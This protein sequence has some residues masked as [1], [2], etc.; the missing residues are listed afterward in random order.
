MK[1]IVLSC[2]L[3]FGLVITSYAQ[4]TP[5]VEKPGMKIKQTPGKLIKTQPVETKTTPPSTTPATTQNQTT[6]V[7]TLSSVRVNIRTGN[8]NKEFPSGVYIELW[9]KGHQGADYN[10]DCLYKVSDLKN[11]MRINSNTE[12]GLEK[13]GGA[14]GKFTLEALQST[15]LSLSVG[16]VPNLFTDA[17]KIEGVTLTLEFKDQNGNLHPTLGTKSITFNNAYGFLN[18]EYHAMNCTTDQGFNP[19][20]AAIEKF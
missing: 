16:Y 14:P 13:Y 19:L 20:T 12:L 4:T 8:D 11:E 5:K 9:V 18:N 1:K 2:A 15:G 10:K 7:F 6:S 17:W 3:L